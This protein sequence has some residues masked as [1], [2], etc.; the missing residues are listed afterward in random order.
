[1]SVST[2][3]ASTFGIRPASAIYDLS[4][5]DTATGDTISHFSGSPVLTIS[6]DPSKPTPTAIYY[7]DPVNGPVALPSTVDTVQHTITAALPHF[8]MYFAGSADLAL[9]L[10]PQIVQTSSSTTI[11][12]TVTQGGLGADGATVDFTVGGSATFGGGVSSCL[13]ANGGICTVTISDTATEAV[14]VEGSVELSSPPATASA[15]VLF[16]PFSTSSLGSGQQSVSLGGFVQFS[17][18]VTVTS[19][20]GL[21]SFKLADGT[22]VSGASLYTVGLTSG[23]I[24]AGAGAG[25]ASAAGLQGTISS[26]EAAFFFKDSLAW[27]AVEATFSASI[28]GIPEL[29]LSAT[30]ATASFNGTASD[31]SAVDLSNVDLSDGTAYTALSLDGSFVLAEGTVD[32]EQHR[33]DGHRSGPRRTGST[34][35]TLLAFSVSGGDAFVGYGATFSGSTISHSGATGFYVGSATVAVDVLKP[36]E[37]N[38]S[39]DQTSFLGLHASI[40]TASIEGVPDF[41]FDVTGATATVNS[42]TDS[43]GNPSST[44]LDWSNV[45]G[46]GLTIGSA[47]SGRGHRRASTLTVTGLGTVSV[48]SFSLAAQSGVTGSGSLG[49]GDLLSLTLGGPTLHAAAPSPRST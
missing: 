32:L 42:A 28:V 5:V 45:P 3:D 31:G 10:S 19:S 29:T 49:T 8:S 13:T 44:H 12:A 25:T 4:A 36:V 23:T 15:T 33:R 7:L 9:S 17:G 43:S 18:A 24:F 26:L 39:T 30:G 48:S 1:M 40:G 46:S 38:S 22:A 14:T 20:P 16:I 47:V 11:T 35:S 27:Q 37:S 41:T 34:D 6:Y 21:V 2:T